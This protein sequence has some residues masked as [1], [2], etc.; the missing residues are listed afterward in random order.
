MDIKTLKETHLARQ[1][2]A[3]NPKHSV[4]VSA[5]A[6]A[7]KTHILVERIIRLLLPPYNCLPHKILCITY[8]KA[9]ATE[10]TQR[11]FQ[12][13]GSWISKSDADLCAEMTLMMGKK[14]TSQDI[15]TARRL[16]AKA[17]EAP[18]GLKIQTIHGFCEHILRRFPVESGF[19]KDFSL[20]SDS[21]LRQFYLNALESLARHSIQHRESALY[22]AFK[23]V[24]EVYNFETLIDLLI[25]SRKIYALMEQENLP[26]WDA[27]RLADYLSLPP[28]TASEDIFDSFCDLI[29]DVQISSL[30]SALESGSKNDITR[31]QNLKHIQIQGYDKMPLWQA[32]FLNTKQDAMLSKSRFVTKKI[33]ENFPDLTEYLYTLYDQFSQCWIHHKGFSVFNLTKNVSLILL[34]VYEFVDQQKSEQNVCDFD[35]IILRTRNLLSNADIAPWV[36]WKLDG[37]IHHILVDEAQDTSAEQWDIIRALSQEFFAGEGAQSNHRTIFAV[38][39]EK[40][41]IYGFQGAAPDKMTE[42]ATYF[43]DATQ[44]AGTP[45]TVE[46]LRG[47]FRSSP[48]IMAFVDHVFQQ[49]ATSG[50]LFGDIEKIEHYA[51]A[52]AGP[53]Y[54][55]IM[56][57]ILP[58]EHDIQNAWDSP[59]DAPTETSAA[60]TNARNIALKIQEILQS[61]DNLPSTGKPAEPKDIMILLQRRDNTM[62]HLT[63]ELKNLKIPVSGLDRIDLLQEI[64]VLDLLAVIDFTLFPDDDLTLAQI[65]RSPLCTITEEDLFDLSYNR[66]GKLWLSL[67]LRYHENTRF[68][69]AYEFLSALLKRSDYESPF[70]FLSFIL[71]NYEGRKKFISRLGTD[72]IDALDELLNKALDFVMHH[73]PSLQK[74]VHF[75]RASGGSQKR[76]IDSSHN[77]IQMM[78]IHGSKGL[79]APIV[80]LPNCCD[81]P[82]INADLYKRFILTPDYIPIILK[83]GAQH[84]AIQSQK[85]FLKKKDED[86][87][88]RLLYVALTRAKDQL[89]ISGKLRK[90]SKSEPKIPE[91]S[92]YDYCVKGILKLEDYQEITHD[93]TYFS[94]YIYQDNQVEERKSQKISPQV[95]EKSPKLSSEVSSEKKQLPAW[96]LKSPFNHHTHR[97]KNFIAPSAALGQS[98]DTINM[99]AKQRGIIIHKLLELLVNIKPQERRQAADRFLNNNVRLSQDR[100]DYMIEVFNII[101]HPEYSILLDPNG[102]S[103]VPIVGNIS[104]ADNLAISGQIDR[105][106]ITSDKVLIADYKTDR[107]LTDIS[108]LSRK[109]I[110]QMAL[111]KEALQTLYPHKNIECYII[112]TAAPQII[113]LPNDILAET[114]DAYQAKQRAA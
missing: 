17:L 27:D 25:S 68:Q 110:L 97:E 56:P 1:N 21:E 31:A 82:R 22:Q 26:F 15:I 6:G 20:L 39:D 63:R 67:S 24:S 32:F 47:S 12:R 102:F 38:G 54:I 4:W 99:Q 86:E 72:C 90:S 69:E 62:R 41:S 16:F 106:V 46:Y 49:E 11:L 105:L 112:A 114:F 70:D 44:Y 23:G 75:I 53:G 91:N 71:E 101:N 42:N 59:L 77:Q 37:G 87:N 73:S 40:Q 5:N 30:V 104:K 3:S 76:E 74:F 51:V 80:F 81:M 113:L 43:A 45:W 66:S 96:A 35:D 78:T 18:G 103:E 9:A 7:G 65:L 28:Y 94:S 48:A 92:W 111:Y 8:T 19:P 79:E 33:Q 60:A 58:Q 107:Y 89:F 88:R 10:M 83:D 64:A 13:L 98:A 57:P 55:E 95:T 36:L 100:T 109:Y 34:A 52:N 50:V 14:P 84:P 61:S 108:K 2:S 29:D 93:D 85:D